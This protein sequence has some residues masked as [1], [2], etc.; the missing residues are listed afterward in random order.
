MICYIIAINIFNLNYH[1]IITFQDE[2]IKIWAILDTMLL[3]TYM[4]NK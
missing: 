2:Y 3:D 1:F 4:P